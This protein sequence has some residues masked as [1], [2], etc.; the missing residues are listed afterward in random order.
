MPH[1]K[2]IRRAGHQQR[3]RKDAGT[4]DREEF[5]RRARELDASAVITIQ[6]WR[7]RTHGHDAAKREGDDIQPQRNAATQALD[8]SVLWDIHEPFHARPFT[9]SGGGPIEFCCF[10]ILREKHRDMAE[11][12]A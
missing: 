2:S 4:L 12:P 3:H 9:A 7:S 5:R 1:D 11:V 10:T 8:Q 6:L